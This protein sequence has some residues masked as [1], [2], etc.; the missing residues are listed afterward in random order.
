MVQGDV[1]SA[2]RDALLALGLPRD[3]VVIEE[4]GGGGG[5]KKR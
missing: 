5:G 4:A 1:A 2:V 3:C